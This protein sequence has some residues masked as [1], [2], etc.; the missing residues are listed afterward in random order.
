MWWVIEEKKFS[1]HD[2]TFSCSPGKENKHCLKGINV[3][4]RKASELTPDGLPQGCLLLLPQRELY[5][6]GNMVTHHGEV[7]Q[8]C[9]HTDVLWAFSH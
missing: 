2:F 9:H 7:S 6:L 3:H 4:Y 8:P 5:S 1:S